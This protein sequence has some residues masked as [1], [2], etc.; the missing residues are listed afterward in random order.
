MPVLLQSNIVAIGLS[1]LS[2][3]DITNFRTGGRDLSVMY[4]RIPRSLRR[5]AEILRYG[6]VNLS[7]FQNLLSSVNK[8]ISLLS[9]LYLTDTL[10]LFKGLLYESDRH[11]DDRILFML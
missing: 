11:S 10:S 2:K 7:A 8:L 1:T 4:R 3:L 9:A 6:S 5:S